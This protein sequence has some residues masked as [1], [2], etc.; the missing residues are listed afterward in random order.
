[1]PYFTKPSP[2]LR[3]KNDFR[4][5]TKSRVG[6]LLAKTGQSFVGELPRSMLLD[7]AFGECTDITSQP[8]KAV[9][10]SS[11][12]RRLGDT[13][14]SPK[15]LKNKKVTKRPSKTF[16]LPCKTATVVTKQK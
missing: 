16:E 9:H 6:G 8:G 15:Q 14:L 12:S 7:C 10:L 1:M 2:M 3:F 4:T 11:I 5:T 13:E